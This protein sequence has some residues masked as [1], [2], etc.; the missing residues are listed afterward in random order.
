MHDQVIHQRVVLCH[1]VGTDIRRT[2]LAS[3][4]TR[5]TLHDARAKAYPIF[6]HAL[7]LTEATRCASVRL[8][9]RRVY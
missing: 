7:I 4:N 8:G 9:I 5:H 6:I 2:S 1:V 3:R